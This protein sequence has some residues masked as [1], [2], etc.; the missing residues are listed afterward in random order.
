MSGQPLKSPDQELAAVI[1]N[2]FIEA[3]LLDE[4]RAGKLE[5]RLATGMMRDTD[6]RLLFEIQRPLR[7][8]GVD[9]G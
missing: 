5:D 4:S 6:W 9:H 3:R 2:A 8:P 1:T 7:N